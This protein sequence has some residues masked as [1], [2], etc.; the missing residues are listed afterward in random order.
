MVFDFRV[1]NHK[2]VAEAM[3]WST[4]SFRVRK[5]LHMQNVM[6][7]FR[8]LNEKIV[9]KCRVVVDFRSLNQIQSSEL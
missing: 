6:V 2:K 8:A 9:E 5:H 3:L 7:E 1:L 4:L